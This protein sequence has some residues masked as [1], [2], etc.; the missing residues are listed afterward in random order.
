MQKQFS[1]GF[2]TLVLLAVAIVFGG[3]GRPFAGDRAG[4]ASSAITSERRDPSAEE[5]A[6]GQPDAP[7]EASDNRVHEDPWSDPGAGSADFVA[8]FDDYSAEPGSPTVTIAGTVVP[9]PRKG[10]ISDAAPVL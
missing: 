3:N 2:A 1:T 6:P 7:P 5:L 9:A 10:T 4:D 8:A